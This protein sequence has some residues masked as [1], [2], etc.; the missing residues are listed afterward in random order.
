M[1]WTAELTEKSCSADFNPADFESADFETELYGV[2]GALIEKES[3]IW[4]GELTTKNGVWSGNLT[5]KEP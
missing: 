3:L 4:T 1:S 5:V 2:N